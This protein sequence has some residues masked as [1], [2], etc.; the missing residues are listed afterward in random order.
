MG[1]PAKLAQ[2]SLMLASIE[3]NGSDMRCPQRIN[4]K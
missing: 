2:S 3:A 4:Q 1:T